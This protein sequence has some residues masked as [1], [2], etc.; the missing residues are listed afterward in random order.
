[1]NVQTLNWCMVGRWV[2]HMRGGTFAH[3][4][5]GRCRTVRGECALGWAVHY[6]AGIA[7]TLLLL[8]LVGERWLRSPTATPALVFGVVSV[9]LPFFVMQPGMGVGF[10]A[11]KAPNPR[12]AC[13]R[14]LATHTVFGVGLFVCAKI[15]SLISA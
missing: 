11:S 4:S 15:L 14:S 7:L 6:A 3:E 12:L 8:L 13:I 10:M 9:V 1:M 5:I 2:A